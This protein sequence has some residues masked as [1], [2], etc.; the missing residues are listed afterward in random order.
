VTVKWKLD[1]RDDGNVVLHV[2]GENG[3][4]ERIVVRLPPAG[5]GRRQEMIEAV[6]RSIWLDGEHGSGRLYTEHARLRA[7]LD[8]LQ[9][10]EEANAPRKEPTTPPMLAELLIS[11]L[12]PKNSA[13]SLLGDLHEMLQKNADRFGSRQARRKYWIEVARSFGP[14]L[15]QWVKRIA[16]VAVSAYCAYFASLPKPPQ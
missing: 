6:G 4:V 8:V 5:A 16:A 12:A 10:S 3:T 2:E 13:Q 9:A 11:F 15:W 1:E 14:L 7:T